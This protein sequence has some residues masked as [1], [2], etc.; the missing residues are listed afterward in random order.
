MT[1]SDN[2]GEHSALCPLVADETD[3]GMEA[4]AKGLATKK[5]SPV[6]LKPRKPEI[7]AKLIGHKALT[8]TLSTLYLPT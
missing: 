3:V 5:T 1:M 4:P 7:R 6:R 2:I 8:Q